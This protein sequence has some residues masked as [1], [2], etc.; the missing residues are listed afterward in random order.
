MTNILTRELQAVQSIG[1]YKA[2]CDRYES[3]LID[4][5]WEQLPINEQERINEILATH[6]QL[7]FPIVNQLAK[8]QSLDELKA[9]KEQHHIVQ[10]KKAWGMLKKL[11]PDDFNRLNALCSEEKTSTCKGCGQPIKWG[12]KGDK[13]HPFNLDGSSHFGTCSKALDFVPKEEKPRQSK[14]IDDMNLAD[15]S[16]ESQQLFDEI[17]DNLESEENLIEVLE[18]LQDK[19]DATAYI[20]D[21]FDVE[22]ISL[23]ARREAILDKIDRQILAMENAQKAITNQLIFWYQ[24]G[25]INQTLTGNERKITLRNYPIVDVI[26]NPEVLPD[27]LKTTKTTYTPKKSEIKKL[28]ESGQDLSEYA[29]IK[30]NYRPSFGYSR[31]PKTK[32]K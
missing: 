6:N 18:K 26:C 20:Y 3:K 28:I 4:E 14:G 10:I 13:F 2:L 7:I 27:E 31:K 23:K 5:C 24:Q 8:C 30:D 19:V 1:D 29:Q 17:L 32:K 9:V 25:K 22:I 15:L 11:K 21:A 12:K 16:I